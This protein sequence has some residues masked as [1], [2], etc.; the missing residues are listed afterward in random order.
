MK[1]WPM[2]QVADRLSARAARRSESDPGPRAQVEAVLALPPDDRLQQLEAEA[3]VF[4][5]ARPVA[6]PVARLT[7]VE[8]RPRWL[9]DS[10]GCP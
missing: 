8:G 9:S 6:R 10:E 3:A 2:W 7:D 4:A 5:D 1:R